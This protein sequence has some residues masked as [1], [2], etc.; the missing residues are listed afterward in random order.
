MTSSIRSNAFGGN[1]G[2]SIEESHRQ[3]ARR[4]GAW[5]EP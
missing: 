1:G 4:A 2:V 5:V 3:E